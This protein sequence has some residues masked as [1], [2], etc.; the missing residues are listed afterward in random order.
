MLRLS[1][2]GIALTLL[3]VACGGRAA[4]TPV[5]APAGGTGASSPEASE[6]AELTHIRLPMGYI[7][8]PQYA[9]IYVAVDRGYFAEEG[10]ELEF[11]YSFETDGMALVGAGEL[12]FAIVSGEQVILARAQELPVVY[13]LEWW[14]RFPVAVVS[15]AEQGIVQP[16]DL[17]GRS[18]G[19]PGL[20]GA[21]YVGL[22]GLL[23]ANGLSLD[24]VDLTD[25][26]FTQVE[27]LVTDQVEAVVVYA[28]N[29]PIQLANQGVD[30][31]VIYVADSADLVANG[32]I[33]NEQT[34][35][36]NPEMVKG[37]VR[38]FLRGVADTLA[39]PPAAFE[40]SK[41]FVE[42]LE[43][44]RM[45]VLEAS[46]PFWQADALG[47]TDASS[48]ERT[49]DVLLQIEFLDQPLDD[50]SAAFSNDFVLAVQSSLG[51]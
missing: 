4:E 6:T 14:Q 51:Q 7:P 39:D 31:D 12:P 17:A 40:I 35:A 33:T 24:D 10:F 44:S 25:T 19:V 3:L 42:G 22:A 48:W 16:A 1:L 28:N 15:K 43:D 27:A 36:E 23:E 32:L 30:I 18:V 34:I 29:E 46:L 26:G 11:D 38:A 49:Q 47:L 5:S 41:K 37:F 20:F 50:L 2:I 45:A 8:D 9:P 21:S 13:V